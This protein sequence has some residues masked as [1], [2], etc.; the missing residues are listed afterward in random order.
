MALNEEEAHLE[1]QTA[2]N[3]AKQA[4]CISATFQIACW[5]L[6]DLLIISDSGSEQLVRRFI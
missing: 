4:L 6:T 2:H 1:M 5:V 3:R